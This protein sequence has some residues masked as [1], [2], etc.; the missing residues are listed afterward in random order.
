M[1]DMHHPLL[2][3]DYGR[4]KKII[5]EAVAEA[6]SKCN[7]I[8]S[9]FAHALEQ[10]VSS[11]EGQRRR[12]AAYWSAQKGCAT[13]RGDRLLLSCPAWRAVRKGSCPE[14]GA[15]SYYSQR[16]RSQRHGEGALQLG[17]GRI[18]INFLRSSQLSTA[19]EAQGIWKEGLREHSFSQTPLRSTSKVFEFPIRSQTAA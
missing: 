14:A 18:F 2:R 4:S 12:M 17:P 11:F 8:P 5:H 10:A 6:P 7:A 13:T 15:V 16:W 3:A 1:S 19:C 9:I